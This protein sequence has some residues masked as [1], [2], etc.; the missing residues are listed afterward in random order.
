MRILFISR[1]LPFTGGRETFVYSLINH[2]KKVHEVGLV[3]PDGLVGEGFSLFKY[4][5]SNLKDVIEE[6]KPDILNSHTHYLSEGAAIVAQK[7]KIPFVLTLH[8]DIFIIGSEDNQN[9]FRQLLV[10]KI[11][12]LVTVSK[13]G[14][15]SIRTNIQDSNL[16]VQVINNG[17][18]AKKFENDFLCKEPSKT[19]L[20]SI[21]NIP[22]D[23]FIIITPARMVWYKGLDF[24]VRT[25]S[26]NKEYLRTNGIYFLIATPATRFNEDEL[27]YL[28]NLT[29]FMR[30]NDIDDLIKIL[31][32]SYDYMPILYRMVDGFLLPS[33]SEQFPISILES[34]AS[35]IPVI[36]TN[37][38]GIPEIINKNID[39]LTVGYSMDNE[40]VEAIKTIFENKHIVSSLVLKARE[41]VEKQFTISNAANNYISLFES[42]I[43]SNK[44]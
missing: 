19:Y 40:L 13:Q 34:M 30:S 32:A 37:V 29:S 28:N 2:L 39:G 27:S 5:E 36:A 17:V 11:S 24:L 21:Y 3:T 44:A 12:C 43:H 7:L 25:I 26:V 9:K 8:G 33:V 15:D 42:L 41:K 22:N 14:R 18:D 16:N 38:G 4:D 23:K 10:E 31:F 6:F 20:R 1:Y 35:G